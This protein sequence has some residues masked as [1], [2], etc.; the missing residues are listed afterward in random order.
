SDLLEVHKDALSFGIGGL[1]KRGISN[2]GVSDFPHLETLGLSSGATGDGASL[3]FNR[4]FRWDFTLEDQQCIETLDHFGPAQEAWLRAF[5]P[6]A[7]AR[8]STLREIRT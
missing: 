2:F 8:K 6:A 4:L 5:A 3:V 7:V 1:D